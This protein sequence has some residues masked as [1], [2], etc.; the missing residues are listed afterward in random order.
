MK[1]LR[2]LAA[3][4]PAC[5]VALLAAPAAQAR[6][7][8][9]VI[10]DAK[11]G[12]FIV[13]EGRCDERVTPSSTFKVA[14]ALMGFDAGFLKSEHAP[15]L[16][17]R[18]GYPA[19]NEAWKQPADPQRWLKYSVFWFSQRVT[20]SLGKERFARY[21]REFGYGNA[22]VSGDPGKDNG[23]ERSWVASSLKISPVEQIGFM[24]KL[25]GDQLPVSRRASELTRR[26]I[27]A[28]DLP[29]G[30]TAHGKTGTA[31]P[32]MADGSYDEAHGYGWYVG[33]VAKGDRSFVFARLDQDDRKASPGTGL[34]VRDALLPML[35]ALIGSASK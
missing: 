30:W 5:L 22:D 1:T 23:L 12:E 10:A 6:I 29:G 34:R 2:H 7:V 35:P 3:I 14:I 27:E 32:K 24:R 17:F 4:V 13:K 18:E 11:T 8:C 20:E 28:I 16:P 31:Y 25:I 26:T 19:W 33:W 15:V 21:A 9:T